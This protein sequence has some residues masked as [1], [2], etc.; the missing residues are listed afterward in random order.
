MTKS[1]V[2]DSDS[3]VNPA[4][5]DFCA[6]LK[7]T[8]NIGCN[9]REGN[10]VTA[11]EDIENLHTGE[12]LELESLPAVEQKTILTMIDDYAQTYATEAYLEYSRELEDW[13]DEQRYSECE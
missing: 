6:R 1:F 2:Y 5:P 10:T 4:E 9:N 7:V 3:Q 12:M 8:F 11:I 13:Q